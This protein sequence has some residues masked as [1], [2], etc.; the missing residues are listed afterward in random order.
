MPNVLLLY[1]ELPVSYWSLTYAMGF[2]G[3]RAAM[4]PL[5]LLTIAAM[6]PP[7]YQLKILDLNVAPLTDDL[8]DWSDFVFCS[9][10][11]V[12]KDA[13]K[14]VVRRCNNKRI[15]VVAGGPYPTSFHDEI[16]GVDHIV[17]GEVEGFFHEF[18][19]DLENGNAARIYRQRT[20]G[21]ELP[22][23]SLKNSPVPRYDLVDMRDYASVPLQFS[24]G[25]PY[26]CEFCDITT[27]YGR[28]PR[29]KTPAQ[30]LRELQAIYNSGFRR[31][32]F[33]VDDNFIGN[34]MEVKRLLPQIA[35]WQKARGYPFSFYTEASV[36]LAEMP[37][38][39]DSMVDAG[40]D[41]VFLGLETPGASA[42][43]RAKKPQNVKQGNADYLRDAVRTIQRHGLEVSAGFIIGLDGDDESA[44]DEQINFVQNAGI[45][46]AMIG[47]LTAL[48]GTD[49]YTRYRAEGRL[50]EES[51]GNNGSVSLNFVPEIE[52]AVLIE[53]YKKVL[54]A[55]YDRGLRNYFS[56]CWILI[57]NW[58]QHPRCRRLVRATEILACLR[59]LRIQVFSP[60]GPAYLAFLFKVILTKPRM[61]R[62][63]I[64]LAILGYHYE[65]VKRCEIGLGRSERPVDVPRDDSPIWGS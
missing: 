36:N 22:R 9:A 8:L 6:F 47:L 52:P 60:Q 55:L 63:A 25:C 41:M 10:M 20:G 23:P 12:Q 21:Q 2:I 49:L 50:L 4:P 56:R 57:E 24:R 7:G 34:R 48:R 5:G 35:E 65:N 38:L 26:N 62:E 43:I 3:S 54:S 44:F 28:V 39:I 17:L 32:V 14:R 18:L 11:I 1:P 59:S 13:L 19:D 46:M 31:A 15:P 27:L 58:K 53:G 29:T 61:F 40:F 64:R 37:D 45:P 30:V 42:L 16:A 33:F 51:T